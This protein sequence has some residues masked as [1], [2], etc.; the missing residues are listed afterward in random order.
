MRDHQHPFL[1][2]T[3]S[4]PSEA[5]LLRRGHELFGMLDQRRSVRWFSSD[6]VPREAIEI[7]VRIA[8][9]APSGA[10]QQPWTFVATNDADVKRR[11]RE[12]AE[13]EERRFYHHRQVPQWHAA[14]ARLE[15]DE[16]KEFLETVPWLVAVFAQ[17][18]SVLPGGG[19]QKNYYVSESVGIACGLFITAL[20]TMGLATLTHT[21]NPMAF[22]SEVFGRPATERP[23]ILFPVGYPALDCEVPD[24]RRKALDEVLVFHGQEVASAPK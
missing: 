12:A 19:R 15:T 24:L 17:K 2:Y 18:S 16:H 13:E 7:A 11:V 8:S 23:Y 22:L 3:P 10:H 14:L 20:H 6:P 21:P 9:T 4:R 1:P 5:E